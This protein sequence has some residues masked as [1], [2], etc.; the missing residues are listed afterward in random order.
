MLTADRVDRHGPRVTSVV[1]TDA[2]FVPREVLLVGGTQPTTAYRTSMSLPSRCAIAIVLSLCVLQLHAGAQLTCLAKP[3][4]G[5][6]ETP[7]VRLSEYCPT[8][9]TSLPINHEH[10]H[11]K[12]CR[13]AATADTKLCVSEPAKRG[14]T[15]VIAT[16][17][18]TRLGSTHAGLSNDLMTF[19]CSRRMFSGWHDTMGA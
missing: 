17:S 18:V 11:G 6:H 3:L 1:R 9:T 5:P 14:H 15:K 7:R 12:D 8:D 19:Y 13:S 16:R 10:H 4:T 2:H